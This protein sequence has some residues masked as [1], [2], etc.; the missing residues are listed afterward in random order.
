MSKK[1]TIVNHGLIYRR[2]SDDFV[3]GV[4][5]TIKYEVR[6]PSGNWLPYANVIMKEKQWFPNFDTF[7]CVSFSANNL[8]E[9]QIMHQTAQQVN[10][11]DRFLAKMS[12]TTSEG[13]YLYIVGDTLRNIGGVLEEEWPKPPE[14]TAT[15]A[16]YYSAIPQFVIDRAK[17][18]FRD[19]YKIETEWVGNTAD[20]LR[21]HLKHAPLQF[22][23]PGHAIA[24]IIL[25]VDNN[26]V[27]FLDTYD[28]YIKT[29]PITRLTDVYKILLTCKEKNM[30]QIK[31]Q[32]KGQSR[33]LALEA[34]SI[35]EWVALCKV[36]GKDPNIIEETVN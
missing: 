32:A 10:F 9:M 6:N 22:V 35:E 3:A 28:P 14:A 4:S 34:S 15:W 11:S 7:A 33:R 5:S 16:S 13:N 12:G 19:K 24:G 18:Q 21:Y 23:I 2:K 36:Y 20:A 31:T 29:I 26:N 27:S 1:E 8:C 25:A 17:K 30:S